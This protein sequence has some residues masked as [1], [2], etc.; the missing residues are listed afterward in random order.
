MASALAFDYS[1][2]A[3][4]SDLRLYTL[5]FCNSNNRTGAIDKKNSSGHQVTYRC[6]EYLH[7]G[8]QC[9]FKVVWKLD[10]SLKRASR[11]EKWHVDKSSL[12]L[13]H[14]I[15]TCFG[16]AEVTAEQVLATEEMHSIVASHVNDK[17][18]KILGK[19]P[20]ELK[21][22]NDTTRQRLLSSIRCAVK[23]ARLQNKLA[24]GGVKSWIELFVRDNPG[25]ITACECTEEGEF[26]R[27]F[28]M[29]KCIVDAVLTTNIRIHAIDSGTVIAEDG[30]DGVVMVM[31]AVN[32]NLTIIPIAVAL[33]R[34][35]TELSIIL[36]RWCRSLLNEFRSVSS[37]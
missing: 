14:P 13:Q 20:Y 12:C 22:Q 6:K 26:H 21:S 5:N 10:R 17:S 28:M 16:K 3:S 37:Q 36:P 35:E 34:V 9:P 7:N 24:Y 31:E 15:G 19:L 11:I 25:S 18:E 33:A 30:F 23:N 1:P 27:V 2:R 4:R 32:S 8:S 29:P